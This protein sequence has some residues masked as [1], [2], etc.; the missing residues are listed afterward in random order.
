MLP[1]PEQGNADEPRFEIENDE[2]Q[3]F[4]RI[5]RLAWA[6]FLILAAVVF[7]LT[8]DPVLAS[9]VLCLKFG[10]GDCLVA[11]RLLLDDPRFSRG[12][13]CGLG[14]VG[15]GSAKATIVGGLAGIT[16]LVILHGFWPGRFPIRSPHLTIT[17]GI[18]ALTAMICSMLAMLLAAW[19]RIRLWISG[20]VIES[21]RAGGWPPRPAATRNEASTLAVLTSFSIGLMGYIAVVLVIVTLGWRGWEELV[22]FV[23]L[24]SVILAGSIVYRFVTARLVAALP[25][26]CW[27]E[28]RDGVYDPQAPD[29]P[30]HD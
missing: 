15:Y 22:V 21:L 18:C 26:E 4:A 5:Q 11:V 6:V 12:L 16:V 9:I 30:R 29:P 23:G 20:G 19:F 10:V 28:E 8:V 27:P 13:V 2:D 3:S 17:G 14:Y 24:A 1:M 7:E 25:A